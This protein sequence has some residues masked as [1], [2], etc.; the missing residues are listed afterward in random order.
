MRLFTKLF[1]LLL[2][3]TSACG[4]VSFDSSEQDP[5]VELIS[6]VG[7]D[8]EPGE[9]A[10]APGVLGESAWAID[11]DVATAEAGRRRRAGGLDVPRR[12][13]IDRDTV[14][15]AHED[16]ADTL[17]QPGER[18]IFEVFPAFDEVGV[19]DLEDASLLRLV[20]LCRGELR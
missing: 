1:A 10:A 14:V 16:V 7:D 12:Q 8:I 6:V 4:G 9:D 5:V 13:D 18:P 19:A 15:I 20:Q 17:A 2:L 11:C 3:S